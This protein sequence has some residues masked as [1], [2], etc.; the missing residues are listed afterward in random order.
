MS[1]LVLVGDCEAGTGQGGHVHHLPG[2]ILTPATLKSALAQTHFII[3]P[4]IDLISSRLVV[5]F[6]SLTCLGVTV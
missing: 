5:N 3:S 1:Q 6:E 4:G 2:A